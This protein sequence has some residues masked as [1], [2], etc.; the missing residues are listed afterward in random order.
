[1]SIEALVFYWLPITHKQTYLSASVITF[2]SLI[3]LL[4]YVSKHD[5]PKW[6]VYIQGITMA[7]C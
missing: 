6:Y 3:H 1:M 2:Q 7:K 5:Y 4:K